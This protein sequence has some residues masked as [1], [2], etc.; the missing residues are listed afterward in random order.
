[1]GNPDAHI[2]PTTFRYVN[3]RLGASQYDV[4][5]QKAP[6][7]NKQNPG[8][9]MLGGVLFIQ[10]AAGSTCRILETS[11]RPHQ[12]WRSQS[13][14]TPCLGF[15][16]RGHSPLHGVWQQVHPKKTTPK[17]AHAGPEEPSAFWVLPG[18]LPVWPIG[19]Q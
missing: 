3:L 19:P 5:P 9:P 2:L 7:P 4:N 16:A 15:R 13:A 11:P 12:R 8:Y 6:T 17:P 1:M 10:D 18:P 14:D